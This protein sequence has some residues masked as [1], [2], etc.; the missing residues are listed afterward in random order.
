MRVKP[1]YPADCPEIAV[2][3][4]VGRR[5][6]VIKYL[7]KF[8]EQCT[9][10]NYKLLI[11]HENNPLTADFIRSFKHPRKQVF[12]GPRMLAAKYAELLEHTESFYYSIQ[13][14][15]DFLCDPGPMML[16]ATTL[17]GLIPQI[18]MVR[19]TCHTP[20][21]VDAMNLRFQL[22]VIACGM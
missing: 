4:T 15:W 7:P 1:E 10:P 16:D 9:Y 21:F 3:V 22:F 14:D 11:S 19:M 6:H 12:V 2:W 13:D 17:L 20:I 5:D 18:A 8:V